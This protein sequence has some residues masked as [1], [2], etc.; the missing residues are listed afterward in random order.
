MQFDVRVVVD[1]KDTLAFMKQLCTAK[2]HNFSGWKGTEPAQKY[3]HNQITILETSTA[4]VDPEAFEHTVYRYGDAQV[5]ELDLI[6]EYL[7]NK[8]AYEDVKPKQV[9]DDITAAV[10]AATKKKR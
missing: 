6:C 4:P 7:F 1:A 3:L 9:K 2:P 10:E 5:V 8:A